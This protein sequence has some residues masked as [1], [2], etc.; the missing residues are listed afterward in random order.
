MSDDNVIV[1]NGVTRL[2]I[3]PNDVLDRALR[4]LE[5][6]VLLGFDEDGDFFFAASHPDSGDILWLL[7]L[8]KKKLLDIG[9]S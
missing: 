4:T 2:P 9:S 8:A 7:E 3:P 5:S 1:F 6:V